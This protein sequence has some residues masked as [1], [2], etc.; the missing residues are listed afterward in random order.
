MVLM[1][2][3]DVAPGGLDATV[4]KIYACILSRKINDTI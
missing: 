4:S 2:P 1:L 3:I